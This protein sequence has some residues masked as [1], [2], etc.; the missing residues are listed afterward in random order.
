MKISVDKEQ[1]SGAL[2]QLVNIVPPRPT[3]AILG[4]V[5][6]ETNG[7][8]L[9]MTAADMD[10]SIRCSVDAT[11]D[12]TGKVVINM[13][14]FSSIVRAFSSDRIVV[15]FLSQRKQLKIS[16]GGSVFH[17]VT[18]S[19]DEFPTF[20]F[21]DQSPITLESLD[22]MALIRRVAYAQST[23]EHRPTLCG[24]YFHFHE[25]SLTL[26]ATDGRRLALASHREI[27]A[28][29]AF[30][31]PERTIG[32]LVRLLQGS[33]KVDFAFNGRQVSFRILRSSGSSQSFPS[34]TRITSRV[35]EGNYPNYR[36]VIPSV[37]ESRVCIDRIPFCEAVQR[38]SL[39][40]S[41]VEQSIKLRFSE[42]L[43]ELSAASAEYGEAYERMALRHDSKE[44]V[45]IG[46]NPRYLIEPL[47]A[48]DSAEIIFEFRDQLSA[49]VIRCHDEFLCV[50]M[51]LRSE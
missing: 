25:N 1:L 36:Q 32:E 16:G 27:H 50:V 2:Q 10:C 14:K 7:Q 19:S 3:A 20:V 33:E 37:T 30:I 41:G 12:E 13:R 24:I 28:E 8:Q 31:V 35:L 5:L 9:V 26:V 49:A 43:L 39:I 23:D 15:E 18:I 21:A 34:E 38:I 4:G 6:L 48:I 51:P 11:V 17:M 44:V 47:R 42:N 22:L 46:F 40:A 45:E 29:G